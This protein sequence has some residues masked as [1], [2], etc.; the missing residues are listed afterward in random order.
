MSLMKAELVKWWHRKPLRLD[1]GQG[2]KTADPGS[3][4]SVLAKAAILADSTANRCSLRLDS[5]VK[6]AQ[7]IEAKLAAQRES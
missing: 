7:S 2:M 3:S 5:L 6:Y 1:R 4:R